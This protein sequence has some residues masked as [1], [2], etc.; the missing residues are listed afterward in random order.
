MKFGK[1]IETS[2]KELPEEWQPYLIQYN[3]LKKNIKGIVEELEDTFRTLNLP[4]PLGET[5]SGEQSIY[6][7]NHDSRSVDT[8]C[9]DSETTTA[10]GVQFPEVVAYNIERALKLT[11]ALSF[12]AAYFQLSTL[13]EDSDGLVHP[14]I[15]V[16]VRKQASDRRERIVELPDIAGLPKNTSIVLPSLAQQDDGGLDGSPAIESTSELE[17]DATQSSAMPMP[18]LVDSIGD[19]VRH[20][21]APLDTPTRGNVLLESRFVEGAEETQVTVRLQSDRMFFV[22]LINYIE[23]T[24]T[25]EQAYTQ[26]YSSNVSSLGSELTFVTSPFKH[27]F[28]VWREIF[29]LY[30]DADV[31]SHAEGDLRPTNTAKEGQDRFS[32]FTQHIETIGLTGQFRDPL[33][34]KLLVSFY[35][36]NSELTY[37]KLLQEM[38]ELATRKIIKKHDKRTHLI[39]KTQ[40]PQ[41]I[42][43]DTSTLTRALIFTVYTELV[44]VVP[45]INDYMC[46]MCLNIAWR[47]LRL[48]CS[49]V[50]CS[51]CVVK[52]SRCRMFNCPV[53][54]SKD[55]IYKAGVTNVDQALLNFLKLYFPK[56]VKE[57]QRDIQQEITEEETGVIKS[58]HLGAAQLA[59]RTADL[60]SKVASLRTISTSSICEGRP[61]QYADHSRYPRPRSTR[62]DRPDQIATDALMD[63][64]NDVPK[65]GAEMIK[66][67]RVTDDEVAKIFDSIMGSG[68]RQLLDEQSLRH[69]TRTEFLE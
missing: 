49:H 33:S 35:K 11:A 34:A 13:I 18:R 54:R 56:E 24:R 6:D 20:P 1:T 68:Q 37:M 41:L 50:F 30:M 4:L 23:R 57:R 63:E 15:I 51:R 38:N 10:A 21:D 14:V 39:A 64:L 22:Q 2:A 40:F 65:T 27:D 25:F 60:A 69:K 9:T 26:Q 62:P 42:S 58:M 8:C 67:I 48:E 16:K 7:D 32:K 45:Q 44:G 5:D 43:F 36:L 55:A 3:S 61:R 66:S 17:V 59:R 52:A 31:W 46:P 12:T 28:Q 29:R 47:P 19:D 53:C